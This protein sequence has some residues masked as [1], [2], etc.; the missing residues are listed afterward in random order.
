[1]ATGTRINSRILE[2]Y[3]LPD[4]RIVVAN[5]HHWARMVEPVVSVVI[6]F[7]V[8]A[9]VD[10]KVGPALGNLALVLW[11]VWFALIARTLWKA[12]EWRN[13][14]FVATDKRLLMTYG[15]ITHRVAMMPIRKV[16]DMNYAR[17]PISRVLGYGQFVL[18]SAGQDQAMREINWVVDP[19]ATYRKLCD[20]LFGSGGHDPDEDANPVQRAPEP[21]GSRGA[22]PHRPEPQ[23]R[24][25]DPR[26]RRRAA[27]GSGPGPTDR[28]WEVSRE[29]VSTYQ[30]IAT[31]YEPIS[32]WGQLRPPK[33]GRRAQGGTRPSWHDPRE[34][35]QQ[36]PQE[37]IPEGPREDPWEDP[38]RQPVD[39][40]EH[41][42]WGADLADPDITGPI[43]RVDRPRD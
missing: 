14:W 29:S 30:P 22:H 7:V 26:D 40:L 35:I 11:W 21:A 39:D 23:S 12:L 32:T 20:I 25:A 36:D 4:E 33:R 6:G 34:D 28:G 13:E 43:L 3:V 16:T 42:G 37:D 17:S 10:A 31:G 24:R 5:R 9:L 41:Q 18:E 27:A 19:D 2:R 38:R 15:L 1:M 8:V